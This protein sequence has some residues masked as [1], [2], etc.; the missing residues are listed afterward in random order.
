MDQAFWD[1]TMKEKLDELYTRL[2]PIGLEIL[3][4][5]FILIV[6]I[7]IFIKNRQNNQVR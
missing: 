5:T 7:F 2:E 6:I 1:S 3:V 4:L